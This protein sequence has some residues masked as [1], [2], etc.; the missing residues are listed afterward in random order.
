MN[1]KKNENLENCTMNLKPS[2]NQSIKR[3]M[4]F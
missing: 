4:K 1:N 3:P 2:L